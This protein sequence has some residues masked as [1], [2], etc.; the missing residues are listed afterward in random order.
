MENDLKTRI[1]QETDGGLAILKDL[2][3]GVAR[4]DSHGKFKIR[5]EKTP[6]AHLKEKDG[7][8]TVKD[9]GDDQVRRN[10]IDCWMLVHG[11]DQTR[12]GEACK[13]IAA[14]YGIVDVLTREENQSRCVERDARPD[15]EEGKMYWELRDFTAQELKLLGP[16]VTAE[17]CQ[18]LG[19]YCVAWYGT[20]KDRRIKEWHSDPD[21]YP[22]FM[23]ECMIEKEARQRSGGND[24][25]GGT[26]GH[27]GNDGSDG[28]DGSGGGVDRF[29]KIYRPKEPEKQWRFQYYPKNAMPQDYMHG[30]REMV[31][32]HRRL[33]KEH[34]DQDDNWQTKRISDIQKPSPDRGITRYFRVVMCSGER[35]ALCVAARG[36]IPL[37]ANSE[38][39][40][41]SQ[42][43]YLQIVRY[44]GEL[45]NIPDLDDTGVRQG[46]LKALS[47]PNIRTVWLPSWL[48]ERKDN[49]GRPCKDFRDWCGWCPTMDAYND[50]MDCGVPARFWVS[51][52]S[53]KTGKVKTTIDSTALHNFLRLHGFYR[54]KDDDVDDDQYIRIVDHIVIHKRIRDIRDFVRLWTQNE[55]DPD[56][57]GE[58]LRASNSIP[59][60]NSVRNAVLTDAR[61]SAV[62]LSALPE[63]RPDFTQST[64]HSQ[65]MFFR[66]GVVTVTRDGIEFRRWNEAHMDTYC[67]RDKVIDHELRLP[68]KDFFHIT[69]RVEV[70]GTPAKYSD[71]QPA[72]DIDVLDS[73]TS[74]YFSY[75]INSSRL[76]WRKEMELPYGDDEQRLAYRELHRFDIAGEHLTPAEI[77]EQKRCLINK[78]FTIGYM[79][80]SWKA[81]ARAW[82]P[83][84]MDNRIA[85]DSHSNGRSGKSVFFSILD[86]VG[87]EIVSKSGRNDHLTENSF[88]FER[89]T[90]HTDIVRI[91]DLSKRVT[92]DAFFDTITEGMEVNPKNISSYMLS[93]EESPKLAFTTNYVPANFDPSSN[94]RLLYVVFGDYY[95]ERTFDDDQNYLESR[96]VRD[97][98]NKELWSH[99]YTGDEWNGDYAFLLQC[100]RF[101]LSMVDVPYRLLPPMGNI[102]KR[103]LMSRMGDNFR[104][105]AESYFAPDGTHVNCLVPKDDAYND[106]IRTARPRTQWT[107]KGFTMTVRTFCQWAPW[108]EELNP[109]EYQNSQ[110]RVFDNDAWVKDA[111]GGDKHPECYYLKTNP[112]WRADA[113]D[114]PP[115]PVTDADL[116]QTKLWKEEHGDE[117]F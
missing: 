53:E 5:N 40:V 93:F 78:I 67:W 92:V 20:V 58:R 55:Q 98:F 51:E 56:R 8:W 43:Q 27:P 87:K 65:R 19:Y 100:L 28:S 46:T 79:L 73:T 64:A 63:V 60:T 47:F 24:G 54:L 1:L 69:R 62:Y 76:Y 9:Y 86:H 89:V 42:K 29:Y 25:R 116:I 80:H 4:V 117:A 114:T 90:R 77:E 30:F 82:A 16:L 36:D 2:Y 14:D 85:E 108:I 84:A 32:V 113:D 6:S 74:H 61:L 103:N 35:D 22:I 50:L 102:T 12:F 18:R 75:L 105:W 109:R 115:P 59:V 112:D 101:Y 106:F 72:Y 52:T 11:Y 57:P 110:G 70:D 34:G 97:D 95:H 33:N 71:G 44:A 10:A 94:A 91:D 23:R 7:V 66:N 17:T 99:D 26:A 111:N 107:M 49:R 39:K 3:P 104:D 37:W 83:Y 15:E 31:E 88:I 13:A 96:S 81:R 41:L 45:Y 38:T 48:Q 21:R 68:D